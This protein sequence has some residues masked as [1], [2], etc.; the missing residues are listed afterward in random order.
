[1]KGRISNDIARVLNF[2]TVFVSEVGEEDQLALALIKMLTGG[3]TVAARQLYKEANEGNGKL[4]VFMAVNQ[5]PKVSS[6]DSG[7]RRRLVVLPFT[8]VVTDSQRDYELKPFLTTDKGARR[9]ILAWAVDGARIA[10]NRGLEPLPE[11]VRRITDELW[12]EANPL[13]SFI[14]EECHLAGGEVVTSTELWDRYGQWA[15][16]TGARRVERQKF[17]AYLKDFGVRAERTNS[18]R[19]Y[20][21]V[22]LL[23]RDWSG[24]A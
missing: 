9:A 24:A 6:L 8:Q 22:S 19:R 21:G 10:L 13:R 7:A 1:M 23:S 14:D 2:R 15:Q 17:P 16:Q 4:N 18:S 5:F 12:V 20:V 3:D 11:A